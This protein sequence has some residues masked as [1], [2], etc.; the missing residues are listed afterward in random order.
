[1]I[2]RIWHGVTSPSNALQ[3]EQ[4]LKKEIFP[5]I[6]SKNGEGYRGIQL[7]RRDLE[8]GDIEFM[9]IMWFDSWNDV[10]QFAGDE[11][12]IAYV[13]ESA[14]Q[15]LKKFDYRSRHYEIVEMINYE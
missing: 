9:T 10:K 6:K 5:G 2:G 11:Y 15:L 14:R 3:Y 13:P 4:L 7:F 12:E 1:M 8:S